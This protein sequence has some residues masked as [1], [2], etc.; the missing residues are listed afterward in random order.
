MLLLSLSTVRQRWTLF[1][2][3]IV[4][5]TIGVALVQASLLTLIAAAT[6]DIPKNLSP[7]EDFLVRD[8]YSA[9]VALMGIVLSIAAFVAIF[10]VGSTFAFTVAQRRRDFALLRLIGASRGQVRR[11]L[12]GEAVILGSLGAAFGVALGVFVARFEANL[13]I[14]FGFVP[15]D[16]VV[17]WRSWIL[18]VS[19]SAGIGI[20]LAGSLGAARRAGRV[21]PLA[22]LRATAKAERV[23]TIG[24][25]LLGI[26]ATG[27]AVAMMIVASAVGSDGALALTTSVC[28]VWIIALAALSPVMVPLI[29]GL[30]GLVSRLVLPSSRLRE[31]IHANLRDG[32]RRSAS[33]AAPVMLLIGLLVGL[34]G[35]MD[36]MGTGSRTEM[37]MTLDGD[38][39]VTAASPLADELAAIPGI[40]VVS[41]EA[42]V[43]VGI[44]E[45]RGESEA[46]EATLGVAI[47]PNPY[48]QTHR[49]TQLDGD[50]AQLEEGTVALS[51]RLASTLE[52]NVGEMVT[53]HLDG[54]DRK[55]LLVAIVDDTLAQP[56]V[57]LP[58]SAASIGEPHQ[59]IVKTSAR[60]DVGAAT[61]RIAAIS[62]TDP[63]EVVA[64]G[65]WIDSS[66]D[67]QERT[68][69]NIVFAIVGLAALY[70][71]V[72]VVNSVVIAAADRR[73]EFA[74][75]RLS[76]L[77][78]GQV[79]RAS[80]WESLTVAAIG[81]LLGGA[82]AAGTVFGAAAAVSDI[83]GVP[84]TATPWALFAAV[85]LIAAALV[86]TT[87]V[88]TTITATRE[89]PAALAGARQ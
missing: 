35:A 74:I 42:P 81:V 67:E 64:L 1:V 36:A 57:L 18:A 85:S 53:L 8:G 13:L 5:V 32:V 65:D 83:V 40:A 72:A 38:L 75:A 21:R 79:I 44:Y 69:R 60:A 45:E 34:T 49:R 9:A 15:D 88:F 26:L 66:S 2:G 68:S 24:R 10:V 73:E 25:W 63:V 70:S 28:L 12:F 50:I 23:M 37:I 51:R 54:A 17:A 30:I 39:I 31:L 87:T 56:E 19:G 22:A 58:L 47:D 16:F 6:P 4:T 14:D 61:E 82:V 59:F 29:G 86:L 77:S 89:P 7:A 46:L 71:G 80:A 55:R 52:A 62:T 84:I 78:R 76:G 20:A 41:E 3:A 43:V 27:G 11:Q 33:T 48:L